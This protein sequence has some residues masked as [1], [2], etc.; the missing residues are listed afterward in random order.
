MTLLLW[1]MPAL[2]V[3]VALLPLLTALRALADEAAAL[4][5]ELRRAGSLR[6]AIVAA[7]T[8]VAALR[9]QLR[10]RAADTR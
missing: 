6:P 8:D 9:S 2:I 1:V 10:R 7:S 3:G 4:R 5:V